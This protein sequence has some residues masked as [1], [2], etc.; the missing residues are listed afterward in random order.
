MN[1][2]CFGG[3]GLFSLLSR[4]YSTAGVSFVFHLYVVLLHEWLSF[5]VKGAL[6]VVLSV[7][8]GYWSLL[9]LMV[10]LEYFLAVVLLFCFFMCGSL[11][12]WMILFVV[13]PS[14]PFVVFVT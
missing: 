12:Y 14:D 5:Y 9:F 1:G 11:L 7:V 3:L 13:L 6:R 10:V 2:A 4:F 8:D